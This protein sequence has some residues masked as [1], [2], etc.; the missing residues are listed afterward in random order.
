MTV[1]LVLKNLRKVYLAKINL[2][3]NCAI[4]DKNYEHVLSVWKAFKMKSVKDYHDFF[5]KI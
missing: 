4:S 2:L 3:S 5:V 1:G